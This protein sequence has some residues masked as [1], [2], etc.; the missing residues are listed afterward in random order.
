MIQQKKNFRKTSESST[1]VDQSNKNINS[2]F[3]QDQAVS[4]KYALIKN[5]VFV[6]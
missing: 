3:Y 1:K 4:F 5:I 2:L 6:I